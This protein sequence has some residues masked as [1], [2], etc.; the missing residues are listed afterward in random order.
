V[1]SSS[2]KLYLRG[3]VTSEA[4]AGVEQARYVPGVTQVV[5]LF[6]YIHKPA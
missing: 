2:G 3:P 5:K 1:V 6:E 4:A